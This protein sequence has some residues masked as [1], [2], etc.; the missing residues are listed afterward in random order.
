MSNTNTIDDT[1]DLGEEYS[2]GKKACVVV[3]HQLS[4]I[5]MVTSIFAMDYFLRN[6]IMIRI[7]VCSVLAVLGLTGG[8]VTLAYLTNV[9]GR[10]FSK[11]YKIYYNFIGY[12]GADFSA[13]CIGSYK[14]NT[15]GQ[16]GGL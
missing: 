15:Q 1:K 16:D 11:D 5:M 4:V 12:S 7:N 13:A 3:V 14:Y 8:F 10:R 2:L 6:K 9:T